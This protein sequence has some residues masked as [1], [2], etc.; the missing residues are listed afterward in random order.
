MKY[1]ILPKNDAEKRN[2]EE[3]KKRGC[4]TTLYWWRTVEIDSYTTAIELDN[5]SGLSEDELKS[6]VES[7][8][9]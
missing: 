8:P 4:K 9:E 7:L 2:R 5:N 1:L 6:L 3:A